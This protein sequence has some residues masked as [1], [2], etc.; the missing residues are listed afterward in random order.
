MEDEPVTKKVRFVEPEDFYEKQTAKRQIR[1]A[2][3]IYSINKWIQR[4]PVKDTFPTASSW[5]T[6]D[7]KVKVKAWKMQ[8]LRQ[9]LEKVTK[10]YPGN[11][12]WRIRLSN[13][14]RLIK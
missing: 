1:R 2:G 8:K 7:P 6:V 10:L 4:N 12:K 9:F 3:L 11:R 5:W 13:T 14:Y